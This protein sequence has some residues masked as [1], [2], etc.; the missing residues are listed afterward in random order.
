MADNHTQV[1]DFL[2]NLDGG[3]FE[4]RLSTALSEVAKGVVLH[5]KQGKVTITLTMK[6]IGSSNQVEVAHKLDFHA[7]TAK[8]KFGEE[9]TTVTPMHVGNKGKLSLFPENQGDLF[10][11]QREASE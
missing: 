5:N 6:K 3:V 1:G 2:Q 11:L 9:T 8:G 7:P 10:R 4:E